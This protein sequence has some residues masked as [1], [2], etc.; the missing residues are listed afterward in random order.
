MQKRRV[1]ILLIISAAVIIPLLTLNWQQLKKRQV[2]DGID[3]DQVDPDIPPPPSLLLTTQAVG[4]FRGLISNALWW[5]AVRLQDDGQ[6]FEARQLANWICLLQ[7]KIAEVWRWQG[8]NLSFNISAAYDEP[9]FTIAAKGNVFLSGAK[10]STN[11]VNPLVSAVDPAVKLE[12]KADGWWLE[13]ELPSPEGKRPLV[14]SELLGKAVVPAAPFENR[15]GTPYRIDTDYFGHKRN[16]DNPAP[17]P[18]HYVEKTKI[19]LK[20]WPK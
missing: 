2:D 14:T 7:P 1:T 5:R 8:W 16:A 20:V 17:G 3:L 4:P 11:E 19:R 12:Q 15:N 9:G 13:M 6:H 18:F 10:P